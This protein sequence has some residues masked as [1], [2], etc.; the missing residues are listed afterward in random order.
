MAM[1]T[2]Y[3]LFRGAVGHFLLLLFLDTKHNAIRPLYLMEQQREKQQNCYIIRVKKKFE[4]K[5][6]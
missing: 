6:D 3:K 1:H 4:M 2:V 5:S